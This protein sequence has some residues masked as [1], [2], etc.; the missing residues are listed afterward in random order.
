MPTTE[1]ERL[2]SAGAGSMALFTHPDGK[3]E[4]RKGGLS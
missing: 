4:I 3:T 2:L 1:A